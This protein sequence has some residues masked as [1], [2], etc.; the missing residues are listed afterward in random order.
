MTKK[1]YPVKINKKG[2]VTV[3]LG[4]TG[5]NYPKTDVKYDPHM[6]LHAPKVKKA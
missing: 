5:K 4:D 6:N 2:E 1:A 3:A